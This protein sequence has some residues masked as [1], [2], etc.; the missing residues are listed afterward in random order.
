VNAETLGAYWLY[1]RGPSYEKLMEFE[2]LDRLT[3]VAQAFKIE[4]MRNDPPG[5]GMDLLKQLER[6]LDNR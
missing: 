6:E 1:Q 2:T 4:V 5:A 3:L